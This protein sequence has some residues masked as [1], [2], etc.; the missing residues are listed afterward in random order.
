MTNLFLSHTLFF[1]PVL[2]GVASGAPAL[3][4]PD[5]L[6]PS[7]TGDVK[8]AGTLGARLD[9]CIANLTLAQDPEP[10]VQPFRDKKEV[11]DGDW[12]CEYWGKWITAAAPASVY[13][14]TP[15]GRALVEQGLHELIATRD[16][17][18]YIGT[19]SREH[20]LQGWDVWGRKYVLLGLLACYDA[21]GDRTALDAARGAADSLI[22]EIGP[23]KANIA[24][25]GYKAWK[26]LPS[27]SVLEPIVH[28][29]QRTGE[30]RYLDF[31]QYIVG[32]WSKPSAL[33][34]KGMRLVEDALAGK[35]AVEIDAPKAYEMMSCYEGLCELYRVTGERQ[36]LDACVKLADSILRDEVTIVGC[37]TSGEL[38]CRGTKRQTG[39]VDKPMETCVTATWMKLCYQLLRLTGDARYAD[40][41]EK[42]LYNGLLGALM[43]DGRWWAYFSHLMGVRVPSYVQHADANL[44]CCVLNG[45]RGLVIT[46]SWA[47][48][49]GADGPVVN[50]YSPGTASVL[51]PNGRRVKLE[52][53]GDYPA[54]GR[55]EIRVSPAQPEEFTLALRVPAWAEGTKISTGG[56]A[57]PATPGAYARLHRRWR[58]GDR[59]F[60]T[61][62]LR[63]RLL[64][65]PDGN[66]QVA[67]ARGPIVLS[68]DNRLAPPT[69][70]T[71]T[72]DKAAFPAELKPNPAAA[73]KIGAWMAFDVP[74]GAAGTLTFC[75]YASAGNAFSQQNAFRTWLPQPLDLKTAYDTGQTW[76]TLSHA[77]AWTDPPAKPLRVADPEKDLALAAH[78]A[79][80]TASS[81]YPKEAPCAGRANDGVIAGPAGFEGK[82]WH[83]AVDVP[84]PH[85]VQITLGRPA[86]LARAVVHP[87]D[88]LGY[89]VR[90]EGQVRKPGEQ[91]WTRVFRCEDNRSPAP[92]AAAFP[93]VKAEAFRLVIEASANPKFPNAAQVS[94]IELYGA[95]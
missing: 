24:D 88:P 15:A 13:E 76:K 54:G 20:H 52:V 9:A 8:L 79:K 31:A 68:L 71:A 87:A 29:Y 36:Y 16:A 25:L 56:E 40:E 48:M 21:T 84:H 89:P 92:Y 38:W 65:A 93:P 12:R 95:E 82:R 37:G 6:A 49:R 43:P 70:G 63:A 90:F 18:G 22:A 61:L 39:V 47:F 10:L 14:P 50:L 46:P 64:E 1:L 60:V 51:S 32:Q 30:Q 73:K 4:A 69:E 78:G 33:N 34:P 7:A 55:V 62:D 67:L 86:V 83:S 11:G 44:S 3:K 53:L 81:E 41:L 35:P 91:A 59:V 77:G 72:L 19:R 94:E 58:A 26:G 80:A 66:G 23:G 85:W 42:N 75:D 28:L 74:A 17:D 5:A 27:S 57:V 2:A 45:P